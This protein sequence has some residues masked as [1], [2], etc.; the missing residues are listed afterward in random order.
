MKSTTS[1]TFTNACVVYKHQ[2]ATKYGTIHNIFYVESHD[3]HVLKLRVLE[4]T[5]FDTLTFN[6]KIFV[7][8]NVIYGHLSKDTF[9]YVLAEDVIEKG[10]LYENEDVCYFARFPNLYES[11]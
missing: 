5:H 11:S 7:N 3:V 6:S 9:H 2:S 1:S 8:E 4:D 10:C